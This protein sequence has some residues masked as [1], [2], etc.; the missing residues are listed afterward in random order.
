[1]TVRPTPTRCDR[2]FYGGSQKAISLLCA[3][4]IFRGVVIRDNTCRRVTRGGIG[5]KGHE[6]VLSQLKT[7]FLT[8]FLTK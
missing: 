2:N 6:L 1:M 5:S 8:M 7:K 3:D 4:V